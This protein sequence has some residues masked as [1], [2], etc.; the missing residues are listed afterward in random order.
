[1]R[2]A[3]LTEMMNIASLIHDDV[4]DDPVLLPP[5]ASAHAAAAAAAAANGSGSSSVSQPHAPQQQ[6]QQHPGASGATGN[7]VH[8]MYSP[9]V[10]NKVSILAGDFLLARA[11]VELARLEDPAVVEIMAGIDAVAAV[12]WIACVCI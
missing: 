9:N 3:E 6:Q 10:G 7:L 11:A 1:V 8:Q 12:S 5:P 2:L 4:L